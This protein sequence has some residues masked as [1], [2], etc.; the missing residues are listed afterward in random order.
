ML[1]CIP[2]VVC[3]CAFEW[4][5]PAWEPRA[6]ILY[7]MAEYVLGH[8]E[9]MA[10]EDNGP[11]LFHVQEM[12]LFGVHHVLDKHGYQCTNASDM[13]LVTGRLELLVIIAKIF[14]DDVA[15]RQDLLDSLNKPANGSVSNMLLGV[16]ISKTEGTVRYQGQIHRF[17]PTFNFTSGIAVAFQ[18]DE[19]QQEDGTERAPSCKKERPDE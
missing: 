18:D 7:E 17:T 8:R 10:T 19:K 5:F 13:D 2:M 4:R 11:F 1:Q 15:T 9:Y 12:V 6:W 16:E 14:P 3:D